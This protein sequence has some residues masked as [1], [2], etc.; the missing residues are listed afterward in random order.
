MSDKL[1][2]FWSS[3]NFWQPPRRSWPYAP[4]RLERIAEKYGVD[5]ET[6][7]E[8]LRAEIERRRSGVETLGRKNGPAA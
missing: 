8:L 4:T 1:T 3:P 6:F 5:D 2:S 7:R